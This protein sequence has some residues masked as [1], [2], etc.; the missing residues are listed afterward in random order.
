MKITGLIIDDERKSIAIL[1]SKIER[2]CPEIELIGSTESPEEGIKLI[3]QL[4]P[5]IVFLDIAMPIMS[6]FDLLSQIEQPSFEIIFVTAFDSYAIDAI[7]YCAIGYLVKPVDNDNLVIAVKNACLNI[8]KSTA[9]EKNKQLVSN[10]KIASFA[11]KNIAIPIRDGFD[12]IKLEDI[13]HCEG[14]EGYTQI[15][16]KNG[17]SILSSYNIGYYNKL[18]ANHTFYLIHKSHLVNLNYISGY[19]NEGYVKLNNGKQLPVSRNRRSD[20][21]N[22]FKLNKETD[23]NQK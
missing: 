13:I 21:V 22:F 5:Q 23:K 11:Q 1:K 4:K 17:K 16:C 19:L 18:L 2:F 20:F 14:T 9:L 3:E 6:G 10:M 7:R 15:Y 12:F 8:E